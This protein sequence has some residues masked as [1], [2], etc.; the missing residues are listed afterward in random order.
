HHDV[1]VGDQHPSHS[2]DLS[3]AARL[4]APMSL[5]RHCSFVAERVLDGL[6]CRGMPDVTV[7]LPCLDE[8]ASL[9]VVLAAIP[10]G[11]R[12]P[13]GDNT[14][15]DGTAEVAR[16]HGADVLAEPQPGYGSAVHAGVVAATTPIVAVIDADG[17]LDARELPA[18]VAELDRGADMAI[19]R[20]RAV[21]GLR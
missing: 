6:P 16:R 2:S 3:L 17:S 4:P 9:P 18:L 1:V 15:T 13:V 11:Y 21:D 19:G 8:A 14:S 5:F 7:V 20:R 10:G 12:S